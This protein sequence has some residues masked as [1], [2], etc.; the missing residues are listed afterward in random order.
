M[1]ALRA[2]FLPFVPVLGY[3]TDNVY[4]LPTP[5]PTAAG[6]LVHA[7]GSSKPVTSLAQLKEM[8]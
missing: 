7:D 3:T 1:A 4:N 5:P 8:I 2:T 6:L